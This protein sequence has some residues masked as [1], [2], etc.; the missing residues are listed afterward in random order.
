MMVLGA[1]THLESPVFLTC[2]VSE[3]Q[4]IGRFS[5]NLRGSCKGVDLEDL[6]SG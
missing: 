6:G 3:A 4:N 2:L 1:N 5:I